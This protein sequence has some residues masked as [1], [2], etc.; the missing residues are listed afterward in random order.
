MIEL[1]L[2]YLY[3]FHYRFKA[4]EESFI[5]SPNYPEKYGNN[6]LCIWR[7]TVNPSKTILFRLG[8]VLL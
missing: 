8:K 1:F 7:I 4:E 6:K 2:R 5:Q 3:V